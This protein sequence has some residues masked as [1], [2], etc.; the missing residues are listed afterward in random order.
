M[1]ETHCGFSDVTGGAS[2]S[3]LLVTYGPTLYVDIGFD[4]TFEIGKTNPAPGITGIKAL[5]DTGAMES[6]IDSMLAAQLNLPIVDQ[7]MVAGVQGSFM[8][9]VHFAQ[10]R[11]PSLNFNIYGTFSGVHL[12][13]GGQPH[14]ALIG[15]TF[16]KY[17]N[18]V[19]DGRTGSV[20][21]ST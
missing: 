3:D 2:G 20:K 4:T 11:I 9:N 16:L 19:Y 14:L 17:A 7:R 13:V 6:C 8:V 10:I 1:P 5:V 12:S 21:I 18:M 15:R